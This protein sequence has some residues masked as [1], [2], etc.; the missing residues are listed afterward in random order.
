MTVAAAWDCSLG[1][2]ATSR[3]AALR[4]V[5]GRVV[6]VGISAPL[7]VRARALTDARRYP[8]VRYGSG[9]AQAHPLRAGVWLVTARRPS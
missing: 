6:G 3:V 1:V 4:A 8:G 2:H 9:D 7:P 5:R